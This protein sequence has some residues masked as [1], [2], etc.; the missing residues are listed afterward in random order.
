MLVVSESYQIIRMGELSN[1][2]FDIVHIR[3][4]GSESVDG[5][6]WTKYLKRH[7]TLNVGFSSKLTKKGTWRQVY[8]CL[9]P[10]IPYP[11]LLR[12]V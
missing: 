10:L 8:I 2:V 5:G 12:T 4:G 7:Q 6:P 1:Q 3:R 9:K 11:P